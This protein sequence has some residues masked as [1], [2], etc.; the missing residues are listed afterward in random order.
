MELTRSQ[1]IVHSSVIG[2]IINF[3]LTG[4]KFA[5]GLFTGSV[6]IIGDA[7][8]SL[9]DFL[10]GTITIIGVV[11]AGKAP[12]REHPYG[13]GQIEY[14]STTSLAI[15]EVLTG[16]YAL[17]ESIKSILEPQP[18]E[19]SSLLLLLLAA[20]ILVRIVLGRYLLKKGEETSSDGLHASG[21]ETYM[22]SVSSV[23][24]IIAAG[25]EQYYKL[26]LEGWFGVFIAILVIKAGSRDLRACLG[27]IIGRRIDEKLARPIKEA[28]TS[29]PE[30]IG[31]YDLML[32]R[33]GVEN[34]IGSVHIEVLDHLTAK[35]IHQLT[36]KIAV[37]VFKEFGVVLTISIYASNTENPETSHI[38]QKLLEVCKNYP[39]VLQMHGFYLDQETST[40]YFD[41][42][43]DFVQSDASIT[44]KAV[45]GE[46]QN[47]LPQYKYC[48]IV[49]RDYSL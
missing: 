11:L 4:L 16:I 14:I 41:I 26:N 32:H 7:I 35:E 38:K 3:L 22:N 25:V 9:G 39:E 42:V 48:C 19:F 15:I 17:V 46:M 27:D 23:A 13:Y 24:T 8:S 28:V 43:V 34:A 5:V 18:A 36:R 37:K 45:I 12:D 1:K 49:D 21:E 2:L 44:S 33:Y 30:V 31:A 6:V 47:A 40:I 29:F 10:S 20:G